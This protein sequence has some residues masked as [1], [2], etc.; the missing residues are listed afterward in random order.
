[1]KKKHYIF[2][3]LTI[4]LIFILY[5]FTFNRSYYTEYQKC[6]VAYQLF[7]PKFQKNIT[8]L[9]KIEINNFLKNVKKVNQLNLKISENIFG[10]N[11]EIK[12]QFSLSESECR[13]QHKN[14]GKELSDLNSALNNKLMSFIKIIRED[15]N[16]D[17]PEANLINLVINYK[18]IIELDYLKF[19]ILNDPYNSYFNSFVQLSYINILTIILSF[20]Y[21]YFI[22]RI[23]KLIKSGKMKII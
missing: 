19:E 18:S 8:E 22:L 14:F 16:V 20:L 15:S 10:L 21:K 4:N 23:I 1:M 3:L 13:D 11:W 6:N 2:I 9:G 17:L 5:Q 7:L 12:E